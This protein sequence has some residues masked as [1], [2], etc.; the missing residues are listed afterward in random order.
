[1]IALL[2]LDHFGEINTTDSIA[3]PKQWSSAADVP[4][5][6]FNCIIDEF[7]TSSYCVSRCLAFGSHGMTVP[8]F[9]L[10]LIHIAGRR[11]APPLSP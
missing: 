4:K 10:L 3:A 6:L 9:S 7:V 5:C 8:V 11:S 1:M 2:D